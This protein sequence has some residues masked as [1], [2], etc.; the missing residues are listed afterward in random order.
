MSK[1]KKHKKSR[2]RTSSPEKAGEDSA[3][4]QRRVAYE[5]REEGNY[6][7][8]RPS[9][10]ADR[11]RKAENRDK[12]SPPPRRSS[13]DR[14]RE[15]KKPVYRL[16][17]SAEKKD[18]R[19]DEEGREAKTEHHRTNEGKRG[20]KRHKTSRRES[21][22]LSSERSRSRSHRTSS[23]Q[24]SK[25]NLPHAQGRSTALGV[26]ARHSTPPSPAKGV[27]L[28]L[29]EQRKTLV[30][31]R[32]EEEPPAK[33]SRST[34]VPQRQAEELRQERK[35]LVERRRSTEEV[36]ANPP[37]T[38]QDGGVQQG[39]TQSSG[40][41]ESHSA[42]VIGSARPGSGSA[43]Q[44]AP[45]TQPSG[46]Q[47]HAPPKPQPAVSFRIGKK[48][49]ALSP[50]T[51][52]WD[53][54]DQS[55]AQSAA[56]SKPLSTT[57][58]HHATPS[59]PLSTTTT[60]HTTPFIP[61]S[62]TRAGQATPSKPL[63]TTTAGQATLSKPLSTTTAGQATPSK[64]LSTT[65]AGQATPF[66]PRSTTTAGRATHSLKPLSTR[67]AGQAAAS[68]ESLSITRAGQ[69][70]AS[71]ESLSIKRAGQAAAS[72]EALSITRAGQAAALPEALSI[73]R[74]ARAVKR[75]S[76]MCRPQQ[77]EEEKDVP[78]RFHSVAA[79]FSTPVCLPEQ[80]QVMPTISSSRPSAWSSQTVPSSL[81]ILPEENHDVGDNDQEMQLLEE[82]QQ[83]RCER[84]LEV[85]VVESYG[86]LTA[87]DI[88]PPDEGTTPPQ[89]LSKELIQ[90][91]LLIVMDTNILLSHLDLVKKIRSHGLGSLG[92][93]TV[94]I[95]WVVLQ[96]LDA[97]KNGKLTNAVTRRATPAV[98]YIYCCL[99]NQEPRLTGQ[100]MQQA[101]LALCGLKTENND[102]RVLQCCLQY[103]KLYPKNQTILCTNDKNLCSKA[104]LSG[105]RALS[106][107]DLL[108]E[109]DRLKSGVLGTTPT[110]DPR[111]AC[112]CWQ[113][114]GKDEDRSRQEPKPE[115]ERTEQR[116]E[117]EQKRAAAASRE[118]SECVC[119]LE[120][121]LKGALSAIL[122]QEM[123]EAYGDLW[124]EI[125]YLKPPWSLSD[126]LQC[127]KKHWIA[128]FGNI[129]QRG[130]QSNICQLIDCLCSDKTVDRESVLLSLAVAVELFTAFSSRCDYSGVLPQSLTILQG[131]LQR[132]QPQP[133]RSPKADDDSVMLEEEVSQASGVTHQD[134]WQVFENIWNNVCRLSSAV[135]TALQYHPGSME[136]APSKEAPPPSQDALCCLQKLCVAV[137]QLLQD[138]QR[139]LSADCSVNDAQSLITFI[140]TTEIAVL[141]PH[142]TAQDLYDC[143]SQ[144]EF[145]QQLCVGGNQ[146]SELQVNLER[147]AAVV[148]RTWS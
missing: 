140:Q 50:W 131:L 33:T 36:E 101:S 65:T 85:N 104:V 116:D 141:E 70:A 109:V 64:P 67:T 3:K 90:Q 113:P 55:T 105:V 76:P 93:P 48:L 137:A 5:K 72:P 23:P 68:P 73:T 60:H 45:R 53:Q 6:E 78:Q 107:T 28:D 8:G 97:I 62:T 146:L 121:T 96:E 148:G 87:M 99:K 136:T 52:I 9:S 103:Q 30:R 44:R 110:A 34:P 42:K 106:K 1:K 19:K 143:L 32:S 123:R 84:R 138:F 22:S 128:V 24:A 39:K 26:R 14:G 58:T 51:D 47:N 98:N 56:P 125:V 21:L 81:F 95:P 117:E 18:R 142:F 89:M 133:S 132:L 119:H 135:F 75:T 112:P 100:S 94:L 10:S 31:R 126:V 108:R 38:K 25:A 59:K 16:A 61:R 86:E 122:E 77:H 114:A 69:A 91:D 147:C 54:T 115:A 27:P 17:T 2:H 82:L 11:K 63:S 130:L 127:V 144:Q 57:T 40:T 37:S 102:D 134:V 80:S 20:E 29:K 92:F 88:D 118:L 4:K 79:S 41:A 49:K 7:H 15:L 43:L 124:N 74:A 139:L 111:T 35:K 83:A 13:P 120:D 46:T 129:V 71:P 12:T 66:K 145:R